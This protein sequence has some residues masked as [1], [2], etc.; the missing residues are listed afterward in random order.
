M[1]HSGK[2]L[3]FLRLSVALYSLSACG[4]ELIRLGDGAAGATARGGQAGNGGVFAGGGGPAA[5]AGGATGGAG[6]AAGGARATTAGDGSSTAAGADDTAGA[7][8]AN[9]CPHAQTPANQVVWIGDSWITDPGLQYTSVRDRA[10][11]SGAIGPTDDYVN[12]AAPAT[13]MDAIAKQYETEESG[14]TPVKVLIMDGGTWDP[15]AAKMAGASVPDAISAAEARFQQFLDEVA[16]DGT[17][18]RIV[19]FLVPPL[20]TVPGVDSMR[21]VLTSACMNS[22]VRCEFIDL[23]DAWAGHPEYTA[24]SGIQASVTGAGVIADLIWATMQDKCIAQ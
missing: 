15:I 8:G 11:A 3:R 6:A 16:S 20:S 7:G 21:P 10:R 12:L 5:G 14:S 24:A 23:R 19:Y 22:V 18:E 1:S 4:G 2:A 9:D 13:S 17:V